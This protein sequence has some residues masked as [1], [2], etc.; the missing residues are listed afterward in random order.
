[1]PGMATRGDSRQDVE[2]SRPQE[3]VREVSVVRSTDF[4]AG[5]GIEKR[6]LPFT[7]SQSEVSAVPLVNGTI[8]LPLTREKFHSS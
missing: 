1:M 4:A 5:P 2:W 3:E 8:P 7:A 6:V